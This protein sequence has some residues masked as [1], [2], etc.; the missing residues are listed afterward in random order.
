VRILELGVDAIGIGST[1]PST[2]TTS[3]VGPSA[4]RTQQA[5]IRFSAVG[6]VLGVAIV[7]VEPSP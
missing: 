1:L 7:S 5:R 3:R 6:L 4:A 2:I